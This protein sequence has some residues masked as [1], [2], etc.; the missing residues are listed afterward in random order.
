[1]PR[2]VQAFARNADARIAGR[3]QPFGI[4]VLQTRAT[5]TEAAAIDALRSNPDVEYIVHDR[6]L[7]AHS[8]ILRPVIPA[9]LGVTVGTPPSS[10]PT[11]DSDYTETPQNWAVVQSGGYGAGIPG[12][13]S[14]GRGT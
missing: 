3:F 13:P 1:M 5:A 12:G 10:P 11:Y 14:H 2:G 9:T 4:A 7:S 6:I 8:L